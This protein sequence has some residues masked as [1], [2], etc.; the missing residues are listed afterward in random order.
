M[1]VLNV[2]QI[3]STKPVGVID[4]FVDGGYLQGAAG[5]LP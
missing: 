2:R 5:S 3:K 4:C 1:K